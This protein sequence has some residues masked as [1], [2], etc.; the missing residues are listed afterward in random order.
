MSRDGAFAAPEWWASLNH[1]G[2][3]LA[4]SKVAEHFDA[5]PLEPLPV[6]QQERLRR[7]VTRLQ[8]GDDRHLP[9]LL[10]TLFDVILGLEP[11]LWTRGN[12]VDQRWSIRALTGEIVKP[13][14]LWSWPDRSRLPVF[15]AD[16]S[17]GLGKH[18]RIG[19]N[20]GRRVVSRVIEWL[21][22]ADQRIALVTNGR[23][24]RLIHAGP[25]YDAWCE[26]DTN[27]WFEGGQPALQVE[28][29]RRL[30]SAE[31]LNPRPD[32]AP[33]KLITA[34]L[35]SRKGQA[36][37]SSVLGERVRQA[38]EL[39]IQSSHEALEPLDHPGESQVRRR[40]LY[41]AATRVVMRCIVILFAEARDLLQRENPAYHD[42]YGLNGLR[43]Q[44]EHQSGGRALERLRHRH[45]AWP[46]LLALFRLLYHGS[47]HSSFPIPR[48]GG[49]L[50]RPGDPHSK[51]PILRALAAFESPGND[52]SDAVA[53]RILD[54]LTR[55]PV[56]VRQGRR[57]TWVEA[58][59]DFSDLSSEYIGILYEGLL[60]FELRRAEPNEPMVFLD[61]G[62]QPVLPYSR[63][64]QMTEKAVVDLLEKFKKA[65][66]QEGPELEEEAADSEDEND[67]AEA[68]AGDAPEED[69]EEEVVS[70]TEPEP[71]HEDSD[72]RHRIQEMVDIWAQK[73]VQAARLVP[74]RTSKINPFEHE[75]LVAREATKLVRRL[76]LPGEW[77]LVRWGGTRK[78]AGTFYTRPQ[79]AEPTTRRTLQPLAYEPVRESTDPETGLVTVLEW[80]V[81]TP[82]Q[83]LA[84][85]LCDP[86]M[87]SGSFLVSALRYLTD[88][89]VESLHVHERLASRGDGTVCRL[90]DGLA[91]DDPSHE[92]I[93]VPMDD[94]RF[95]DRLR[96]RLKRY[97]VERCIYGVDLDPLAV[98]LGRMALW[99]E[100]MDQ[101]LGFG[102][103]DHKLKCGNSLVGCWFDR[104][105][106]YP[107]MAWEREGGDK[108]HNQ[109]VHHFREYEATRGKQEGQSVKSGDLWTYA[110]KQM[111]NEVIRPN[112][113]D[114]IV[115]RSGDAFPF[116]KRGLTP[117][118]VHEQA[119]GAFQEMHALKAH[120]IEEREEVYR[121]K[122]EGSEEYAALKA[123]FDTWCAIWFWPGDELHHAPK[124]TTFL[125]PGDKARRIVARLREQLRFFHWELEFPDVFSGPNTGFD[126][127]IGN[128]PWEIQKP[129]SKEFF[130]NIDPLYRSYGKQEALEKQEEYFSAEGST[131]ERDWLVYSA[132]L[133]ALS[134]CTKHSAHPFGDPEETEDKQGGFGLS[135]TGMENRALHHRWRNQRSSR[136]GYADPEHPFRHQG[137]A[138]LN[139]YKMFL[140]AAHSLA[141]TGG[142]FGFIVPSGLYTDKGTTALRELFLSRCKWEW[143]FGFENRDGIFDIHR[144]FKFGPVIVEKGDQTAVIRTAFMHRSLS[145]WQEGEQHAL[146]YPRS[147]VEQFSPKSKALLEVRSERDLEI[148]EKMY[149]NGV[150]LGDQGPDGW[151]IEYRREFDM[152]NDSKLFPPRPKWEAKGYRSDEYG[153]W[154]KG[155][156]RPHDGPKSILRRPEG[157]V[158]SVDGT[159]AIRVEEIEDVALPFMQGAMLNQFDFSQKG[160]ISGTGLQA[161]WD[162]I[163]WEAKRLLPQFLMARSDVL[164]AGANSVKPVIRRIAR[165][166]DAR[167]MI[168]AY[169][170]RLPCGDVA[171]V[172]HTADPRRGPALVCVLDSFACDRVVRNRCGGTHVD[173][174]YITEVPLPRFEQTVGDVLELAGLRLSGA[175]T[176]FSDSWLGSHST[177]WAWKRL[178]SITCAER[179]RIRAISDALVAQGYGLSVADFSEILQD[180]DH[181]TSCSSNRSFTRELA[182]KGFWR[183]DKEAEPELRLS[184]LAQVAHVDLQQRGL[185]GFLSQNNGEGWMLPETLRLADYGIG[186]DDRAKEHQPVASR[187]GPRFYDWQLEQSVAESW[188]ECERHAALIERIV[189]TA[190][191][192]AEAKDQSS[193][194][195]EGPTDLFGNPIDQPHRRRRRS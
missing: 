165:N 67:A 25:D 107:V 174:H 2:L 131:A 192:P 146:A 69:S 9:E 78:G 119:L 18:G 180:C 51:D 76:I 191:Y 181:P 22:R 96:A 71:E 188:E 164:R 168:A 42:S 65:A 59:V 53:S 52:L 112:L 113:K 194:A 31:A 56:K 88:A 33:P 167:M 123:A 98:E 29:L 158:L 169:V 122:I 41:I 184:V 135:R 118:T 28:A 19:L 173:Y 175:H 101:R 44:L 148:L 186:H 178:W 39:L 154:L 13:R 142:R 30:L 153:H 195:A 156:W 23:Q 137:S 11:S 129:N 15:V 170:P 132:Q 95:E 91:S 35:D 121:E 32:E 177:K 5:D 74:R 20:K 105:Q 62:N 37:L 187:L 102:F 89:L 117:A 145:D 120:E 114:W 21:R 136:T 27:L 100:T 68:D 110:I 17:M 73:A 66:K 157:L 139:T 183:I 6:Y 80:K 126:A 125:D 92:T 143:L 82:E 60:D 40:D 79:L 150:L 190:K 3:L 58:P 36:E 77:Y 1:G 161:K 8:D 72:V 151:G 124:P 63:L 182:P 24:F 179:L 162:P 83:I 133:K 141:R 43:E 14:W 97:V 152:T 193:L 93:P 81:R 75:T 111:R 149:Q 45:A 86:A 106:E 50:F 171:S 147:R 134:N 189:P 163:D 160:W 172:L 115:S 16:A 26:W 55:S 140:E 155:N 61:I 7:S 87:G 64:D 70:E 108:N 99:V 116:L 185:E 12:D 10:T 103:L 144:S 47:H 128:P 84:I 85:K 4:P 109:I 46:R 49:G 54:T 90:A 104:F 138:D 166:T 130:S 176:T 159:Q 48:Y 38:V 34:I 127:L 57:S 94:E